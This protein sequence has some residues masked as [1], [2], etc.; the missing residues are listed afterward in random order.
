VLAGHLGAARSLSRSGAGGDARAP[1]VALPDAGR[2]PDRERA[3]G[4]AGA[5]LAQPD[6]RH[7][8]GVSRGPGAWTRAGVG[9]A[10]GFG[11]ALA[12]RAGGGVL[13]LQTGR[14][15]LRGRDLMGR[16]R[17]G[18]K[19]PFPPSVPAWL[20]LRQAQRE[21][22]RGPARTEFGQGDASTGSARRFDR[23]NAN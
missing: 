2:L 23:L 7:H 17:A 4:V 12:A 11:A 20:A 10:D 13:L 22:R 8:P 19:R 21:R 18:S 15:K 9:P 6:G 1:G 5:V 14:A 3:G 16:E